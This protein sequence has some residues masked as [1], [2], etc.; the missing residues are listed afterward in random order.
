MKQS[1]QRN[2][3]KSELRTNSN[4]EDYSQRLISSVSSGD[5]SMLSL[6]DGAFL[7][8]LLRLPSPEKE[9]AVVSYLIE[10]GKGIH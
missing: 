10:V 8:K 5:C 6:I 3:S 7:D 9:R 4:S 2:L 1:I